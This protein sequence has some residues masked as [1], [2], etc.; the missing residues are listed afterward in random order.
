VFGGRKMKCKLCGRKKEESE[1][2]GNLCVRCDSI[3]GDV[4]MGELEI[5]GTI[6]S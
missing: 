5:T 2:M 6:D 4:M 1:L 3:T